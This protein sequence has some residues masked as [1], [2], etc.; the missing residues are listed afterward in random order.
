MRHSK[1]TSSLTLVLAILF[2]V[3][4]QTSPTGR[5]QFV[6]ISEGQ[7]DAMGIQAFEQLKDQQPMDQNPADKAY[8]QCIADAITAVSG[9]NG[10]WEVV[11]FQSDEVNAFALP[12]NKIGVYTGILKVAQTP[13][14]L[15]TVLGHEVGHVVSQHGRERMSEQLAAQGILAVSSALL[16]ENNSLAHQAIMGALGLGAQYGVILPF[17]RAQESEADLVGLHLMAKAGF[18][19]RQAI[20]LWKNMS[21]A[22]ASSTPAFLSDHPSN[23]NRIAALRAHLDEAI[24]IQKQSDRHPNCH[25]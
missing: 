24:E 17:S 21:K 1:I 22:A 2:F 8:I 14:Q 10:Q 9:L 25:R 15:A 19:P 23:E 7:A 20:E 13:D 12:G 6:P 18:D 5:T 3:G 11:V 4:C 16:S